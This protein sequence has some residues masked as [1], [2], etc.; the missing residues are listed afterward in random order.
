MKKFPTLRQIGVIILLVFVVEWALGRWGGR[1]GRTA[2]PADPAVTEASAKAPDT[3]PATAGTFGTAKKWLYKVHA[4]NQVT[5][6]CDCEYSDDRDVSHKE[7][8][9]KVRKS[10]SRAGQVEAE[11]VF[12]A[13]HFGNY[14]ECW[15][16]PICT[17]NDGN[18]FKGRECCEKVD[19]VFIAAHNDLHNLQPSVGEVNGDRS[20]YRWGMIEGEVSDYGR[21]DFELD[22][23]A[24]IAEPPEDV[25]GDIARTYFYMESTYGFHISD[26]QR[27][28]FTAWNDMDPVDDWER[29]RNQLIAE[30]QGNANPFIE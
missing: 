23:E 8:G 6:Y 16:E 13:S 27:Q 29:T 1:W 7:C 3:L 9:Y 14:R 28:L 19:P 5:F 25:Q 17:D 4:D 18:P 15:R 26:S 22:T 2:A 30:I 11:H 24:G 20:D 12:P 21:C 10:D